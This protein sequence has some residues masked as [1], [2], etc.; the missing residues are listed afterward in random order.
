M[1]NVN[2]LFMFHRLTVKLGR[3]EVSYEKHYYRYR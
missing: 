2:K 1:Y 3:K